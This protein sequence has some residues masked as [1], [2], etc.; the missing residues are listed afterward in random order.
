[1][2]TPFRLIVLAVTSVL[3]ALALSVP[4]SAATSPYCGI[5]WGSLTK[6]AGTTATPSTTLTGVRTGQHDCYDRLVLDLGSVSGPV[7]YT[8]GYTTVRGV[9]TGDPIPLAGDGD[10]SITLRAHG[11][12]LTFA[13]R[14]HIANVTG[15]RTFRQVASGGSFEGVTVLGLGV[16][17][18][19]PFR[20][21]VLDGPAAGQKRLVIDV[22]HAW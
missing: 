11:E 2:R 18:R 3:A 5:T 9:A 8:V 20:A 13:D 19:L 6:S 22:A 4:A 21:L 15:Y 14:N 17:A 16:R 12:S 10:L 1:M 7:S